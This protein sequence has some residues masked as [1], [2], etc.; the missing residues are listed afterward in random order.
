MLKK[1]LLMLSLIS[2]LAG[3]MLYLSVVD[4][5]GSGAGL[6][7]KMPNFGL[8]DWL[9]SGSKQ[10]SELAG[11]VT[12]DADPLI[13]KWKDAAGVWQF[14]N[15][16]PAGMAGVETVQIK[17]NSS[18]KAFIPP[19]PEKEE[20]PAAATPNESPELDLMPSPGRVK[21]LIDDAQNVQTILDERI[22]L[23][24]SLSSEQ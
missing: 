17:S 14:T 11:D 4:K 21:K 22:K 23:M 5:M 13:Y 6:S 8:P 20:A 10:I 1:T 15:E 3:P 16:A 9:A 24:D 18:L 7:F 2:I 12:D 19:E